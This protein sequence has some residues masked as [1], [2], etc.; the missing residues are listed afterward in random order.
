MECPNCGEE[1]SEE[2]SICPFCGVLIAEPSHDIES[3]LVD[4]E[5]EEDV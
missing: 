2:N 1:I 4:E 5:D 3:D